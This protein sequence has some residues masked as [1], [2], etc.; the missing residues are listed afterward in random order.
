MFPHSLL[1]PVHLAS[2]SV[3]DLVAE[4]ENLP[5]NLDNLGNLLD[6]QGEIDMT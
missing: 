3:E 6:R 1:L 4:G 5:G 2:C